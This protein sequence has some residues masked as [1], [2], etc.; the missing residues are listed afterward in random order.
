MVKVNNTKTATPEKAPREA[1]LFLDSLNSYASLKKNVT[2]LHIYVSG[3]A[4]KFGRF[5]AELS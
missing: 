5:F 1:S 4:K 3:P 2:S